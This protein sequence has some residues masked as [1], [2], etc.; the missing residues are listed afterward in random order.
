MK[1]RNWLKILGILVVFGILVFGVLQFFRPKAIGANPPVVRAAIW[2]DA[3]S[4]DIARRACYDC[5]S[6]ETKW[7]WYSYVMPVS[8]LLDQHIQVGR[9]IMNF[10]D[11]VPGKVPATLIESV[12][13]E[14][15]MPLPEYLLMHREA[16][17]TDQEK[18]ALVAAF[19]NIK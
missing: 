5:H 6:N 3:A 7:P 15:K 2:P 18:A 4:E 11:W 13:R 1:D 16:R 19:N 9:S 17:L 10:S 14:K 12:F 8:L